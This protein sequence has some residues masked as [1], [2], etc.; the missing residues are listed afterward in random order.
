MYIVNFFSE[1]SAVDHPNHSAIVKLWSFRRFHQN[2]AFI[3]G[4]IFRNMRQGMKFVIFPSWYEDGI[5]SS[6]LLLYS[7]EFN[8]TWFDKK[9]F[10]C[11]SLVIIWAE[12][13]MEFSSISFWVIIH[14]PLWEVRYDA[15]HFTD[16][17]FKP[18][19]S[20]KRSGIIC[21]TRKIDVFIYNKSI[22]NIYNK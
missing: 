16:N 6:K 10:N 15:F 3:Q 11:Y 22:A 18:H 4:H 12:K 14:K 2:T 9:N 1:A 20:N 5:C 17:L 7:E 21:I 19:T 8:G 13:K